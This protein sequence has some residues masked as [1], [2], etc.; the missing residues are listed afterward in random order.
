MQTTFQ[1]K[2]D[3]QPTTDSHSAQGGGEAEMG[4]TGVAEAGNIGTAEPP[5][6][7]FYGSIGADSKANLQVGG[8]DEGTG[9][10]KISHRFRAG[11]TAAL[12]S[13][14]F[15]Q[16]GG[17]GYS[18]GDGGTLRISVR[19]DSNGVPSSTVLASVE[20]AFGNPAGEW[21]TYHDTS[22]SS[23]ATLTAGQLY[24]IV[25]ENT[26]TSGQNYISV[27]NLFVFDETTPRQP[28]DPRDDYAVL[29]ASGG[30][31][32]VL[33][34]YT[35]VMDLTYANGHHD[36]MGYIE[37]MWQEYGTVSG[38]S[39]MVRQR[40]TVSSR[41][42][43][44]SSVAVRM[45]RSAGSSPLTMRLESGSGQL[46]EA[47]S[48]PASAVPVVGTD[49][50]RN[51]AGAWV[52]ARFGTVHTLRAGSTYQLRL[53]T[54]AGTTYTTVPVREGSDTGFRSYRFTD[55][56]GERTTDGGA[57]WSKLYEWS[58]VDLQFYLSH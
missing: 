36:G 35:A 10:S 5:A 32:S 1:P 26:S 8:V 46:I 38:N 20:R 11:T 41:D 57:S 15:A 43:V 28:F 14:R 39:H 17:A 25:F 19:P 21:S 55:G 49:D 42:R 18:A 52:S 9:V 30:P 48:I 27:N 4:N 29:L 45:R 16:R 7:G 3:P 31:W 6:A 51:G 50:P 24:H 56:H 47:V 44:V 12:T 54:A 37:A 13:L 58:P 23:P 53:V 33:D 2:P 40:F 22:F 34:H